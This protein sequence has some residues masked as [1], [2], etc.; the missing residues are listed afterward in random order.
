MLYRAS[1]LSEASLQQMAC[2]TGF[3]SPHTVV[4]ADTSIPFFLPQ[5]EDSAMDKGVGLI[6]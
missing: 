2:L 1:R 5:F 4:Q 3:A 6:W